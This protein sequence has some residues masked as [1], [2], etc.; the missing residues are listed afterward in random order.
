[1]VKEERIQLER[2]LL[3]VFAML[4][5][6]HG[7]QVF[8]LTPDFGT[9]KPNPNRIS[10]EKYDQLIREHLMFKDMSEDPYL[11]TSG[12]SAHWPY[13]RGSWWS[14]DRS[15]GIWYGEEDHLRIMCMK[16]SSNLLDAFHGLQDMLTVI[17]EKMQFATDEQLG[18][19]AS[20]PSNLGTGMRASVHLNVPKLTKD[21]TT[22]LLEHVC[23]PLGLSVRGAGGEH[24][25]IGKDG[26]VDISPK[27][28]FG[29]AEGRIVEMLFAGVMRLLEADKRT[30]L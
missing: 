28:R 6:K 13:G 3:P 19:I 14:A 8:S 7:G 1:M 24:T 18:S 29:V 4:S 23:E 2:E 11:E 20:C 10:V 12:I 22:A 15:L 9:H 5:E 16:I 26:T 25:P 30:S 17:E 21:G 27:A